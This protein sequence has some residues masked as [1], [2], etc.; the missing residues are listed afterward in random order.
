VRG[1][2]GVEVEHTAGVLAEAWVAHLR[3]EKKKSYKTVPFLILNRANPIGQFNL[4]KDD[5]VIQI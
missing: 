5:L 2:V 4:C 3:R 1:A